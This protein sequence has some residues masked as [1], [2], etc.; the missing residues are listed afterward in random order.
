VVTYSVSATDPDDEASTLKVSCTPSSGSTFPIGE[1]TVECMASDPAGN[2]SHASFKVTVTAG[3][4]DPALVIGRLLDEVRGAAIPHHIRFELSDTLTDTLDSLQ[5]LDP[6]FD[7]E[8]RHREGGESAC[9]ELE[10][11]VHLI[12]RDQSRKRPRIPASLASAWSKTALGVEA[13]LGCES[14][15]QSDRDSS[16]G[17]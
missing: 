10:R 3:A 13:S 15:D 14:D 9:Y 12:A 1:T 11:F 16:D 7:A 4:E 6:R 17:R 2:T 5:E 8:T